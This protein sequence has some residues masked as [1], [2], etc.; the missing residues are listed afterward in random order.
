VLVLQGNLRVQIKDGANQWWFALL[1]SN[2][3]GS[4]EV[5]NLEVSDGNNGQWTAMQRQSYNYWI[6]T[7]GAGFRFPLG[8]RVSQNSKVITGTIPYMSAGAVF[9]LTTNFA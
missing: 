2:V 8:V 1:A 7:S 9:E 6:A 3:G 4:G 5:T